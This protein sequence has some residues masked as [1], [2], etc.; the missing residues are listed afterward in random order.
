MEMTHAG[1]DAEELH[2][3]G[4]TPTG[5]FHGGLSPVGGIPCWIQGKS[6][7]C[8]LPEGEGLDPH[9]LSPVLQGEEV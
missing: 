6:V 5:E 9:S 1:A 7:R 4:R 3:V 2:L 8:S